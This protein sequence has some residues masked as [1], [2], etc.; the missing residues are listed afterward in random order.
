MYWNDFVDI[1]KCRIVVFEKRFLN[2]F[3]VLFY[4]VNLNVD[5]FGYICICYNKIICNS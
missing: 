2:I 4:E 3:L 1:I 5:Y